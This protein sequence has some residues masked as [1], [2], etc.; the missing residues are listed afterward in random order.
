MCFLAICIS[1]FEKALFSSFAHFIESLFFGKFSFL[2]SQ[3]SL[4][5]NPLVDM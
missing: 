2:S 1:S 3:Y 4:V 5:I